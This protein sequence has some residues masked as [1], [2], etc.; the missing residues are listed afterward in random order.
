MPQVHAI[1]TWSTACVQEEWLALLVAI[2]DLVK[3]SIA[4]SVTMLFS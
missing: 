2:Q 1:A 4:Q 3:L